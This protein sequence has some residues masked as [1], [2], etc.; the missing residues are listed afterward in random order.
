MAKITYARPDGTRDTVDVPVGVS[1]MRCAVS[2]GVVGIVA[3]CGGAGMCGTCHI[4]VAAGDRDR[5][6]PMHPLEDEVLDVTATPR[7][8][9]SRLSCQMPVTERF[10]G[11]VVELPECQVIPPQ[12]F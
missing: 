10:D 1:V 2:E 4:F 11:L 3:E 8:D 7:R 6:N 9:T 5:V 12:D